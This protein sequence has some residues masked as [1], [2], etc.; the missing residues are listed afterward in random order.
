M[1]LLMQ[2]AAEAV[3]KGSEFPLA[4]TLVYVVGFVAAVTIGSIAWYNSKRPAGWES[5]D[6]PDF[7]P[8]IEKE[9]TPG[10]G[11]PKS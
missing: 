11:K 8:E 9:E 10:V 2:T 1:S 3:T 5:K 6:R 4:F 7:L